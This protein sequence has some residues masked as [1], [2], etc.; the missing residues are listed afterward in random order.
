LRQEIGTSDKVFVLLEPMGLNEL[1]YKAI[2]HANNF[3]M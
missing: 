2:T 1:V 3:T